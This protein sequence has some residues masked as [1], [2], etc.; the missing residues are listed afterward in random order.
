MQFVC[1]FFNICRKFEALI[2]QGSVATCL[3][4]GGYC[5]LVFV[6][7]FI[8]FSVVQKF[9]KSV[10]IWQSYRQLK[11]GTFFETQCRWSCC[12][13]G[14]EGDMIEIRTRTHT[15]QD[16]WE[17]TGR[18]GHLGIFPANYVQLLWILLHCLLTVHKRRPQFSG[19]LWFLFHVSTDDKQITI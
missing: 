14:C 9:W 19:S 8:G 16:W 17:G 3:R 13:C 12:W 4:W 1:F 2:S 11:V 18:D 6:A 15:Q 7:N 5:H 10:K